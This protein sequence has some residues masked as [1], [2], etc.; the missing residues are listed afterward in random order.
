DHG[1]YLWKLGNL[2]LLGGEYNKKS[3]N[4]IFNEK[5]EV[6]E[7][8]QVQLTKELLDYEEWNIKTIKER[9]QSLAEIAVN[10]WKV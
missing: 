6:Y 5:K 9:Q 8:S 1:E 3:T 2:T 4:K 10:I 7:Y